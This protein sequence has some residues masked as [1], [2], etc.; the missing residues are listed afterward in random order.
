[1]ASFHHHFR[2]HDPALAAVIR[3]VGPFTLRP[4]RNRFQMLVRSIV[5]QQ[6]S[7]GAARTIY[8]RLKQKAGG[9]GIQ[10]AALAALE[11]DQLRSVGL[12]QQKAAYISD[13]CIRLPAAACRWK[14]WATAATSGSSPS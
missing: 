13:L 8:A 5:S 4:Q 10:P 14:S 11:F 1:M 7:M 9:R 2:R 12:S 6:I 3:R